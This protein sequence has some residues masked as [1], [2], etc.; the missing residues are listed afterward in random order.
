MKKIWFFVEGDTEEI[1]IPEISLPTDVPNSQWALKKCFKNFDLKYRETTFARQ[2]SPNVDYET[3]PN[4]VLSRICEF[5][6][7]I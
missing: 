3:C 7:S 2:F 4:H 6:E 5:L 1:F